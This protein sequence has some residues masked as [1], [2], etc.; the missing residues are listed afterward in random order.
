MAIKS[1]PQ[2]QHLQDM[3]GHVKSAWLA[4]LSGYGYNDRDCDD[5]D[6]DDDRR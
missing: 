5:D 4:E 2:T 1:R 3:P 6:H